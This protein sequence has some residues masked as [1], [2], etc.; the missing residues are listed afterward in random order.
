MKVSMYIFPCCNAVW[1]CRE[2]TGFGRNILPSIFSPEGGGIVFLRNLDINLQV[3]TPLKP[4]VLHRRKS[5]W[6]SWFGNPLTRSEQ[7]KYRVCITLTLLLCCQGSKC[8]SLAG[9]C[10]IDLIK[11]L[12]QVCGYNFEILNNVRIGGT[13]LR[14]VVT[15]ERF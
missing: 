12:S 5:A 13:C 7:C 6:A 15:R 3:A 4:R 2:V 8:L 11:V 10:I 1:T 14:L 9:T